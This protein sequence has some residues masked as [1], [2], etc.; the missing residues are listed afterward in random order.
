[1]NCVFCTD[2]KVKNITII[3]NDL[4]FAFLTITPIIPG[5]VLICPKR[6]I[7][8]LEDATLEEREAIE[9]LRNSIKVSLKKSFGAQGFNYAWNEER[10]GGQSIPHFHLHIIP[11]KEGDVGVYNYEPREFLY[12]PGPRVVATPTEELIEITNLLRR[13]L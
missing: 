12:R 5:H 7:Q 10:I 6:H 13:N 9:E 1:M 2:L 3:E 11:R 4:A 8:Y